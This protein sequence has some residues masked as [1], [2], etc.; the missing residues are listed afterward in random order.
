MLERG[1]YRHYKGT[2]YEVLGIARHSES[3]EELVLY[4]EAG[5]AGFSGFWV[6]PVTMFQE[7]VYVDG[8]TRPR[9]EKLAQAPG[10]NL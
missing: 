8:V 3:L 5:N 6:R 1:L 7:M 4:R 2:I 10:M 9:F